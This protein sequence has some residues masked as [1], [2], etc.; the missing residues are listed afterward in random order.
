MRLRDILGL[1]RK[2]LWL[3]ILAC[4]IGGIAGL[5]VDHYQP[6]KYEADATLFVSSPNRSDYNTLLGD[7]QAAVA[8]AQYAKSNSVLLAALQKVGDSNLNLMQLTTMVTVENTL[9]SQFVT[10]KVLDTNPN[11]AALLASDIAREAMA[12]F[13]AT[14]TDSTMAQ[15]LQAEITKLA[16]QIKKQEEELAALQRQVAALRVVGTPTPEQTNTINRFNQLNTNLNNLRQLYTQDVNSYTNLT[17]IQVTLV[18]DAQVPQKPVGPGVSLAIAIGMLAGLIA[19]V[20]VILFIEQTD[21]VL[22]TPAKVEKE[23]GLSTLITVKRLPTL[24]KQVLLMNSHGGGNENTDKRQLVPVPKSGVSWEDEQDEFVDE[25]L[26]QKRV[27]TVAEQAPWLKN[28]R[29]LA[30]ATDPRL[31]AIAKQPPTVVVRKLPAVVNHHKMRVRA[32]NGF[33]LPEAFL[34]LGVFLRSE[35]SQVTSQGNN[36]G[37]LLITS[38]EDGDGKTLMSSQIALGL[39]RVGVEVILID[40]NLRK[41]EVHKLFKL[42]NDI[43][44]SSLLQ[45]NDSVYQESDDD[46][47]DEAS[48]IHAKLIDLILEA[49]QPTHEPNLSILPGGPS[50]DSSPEL[51]SLSTMKAILD[52]LSAQAFVI[53]DGPSVLT[54]SDSVILANKSDA[55]LLVVDARHTTATKLNQSL[56]MLSWVNTDILGV[57]LNQFGK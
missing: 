36:I 15:T 4:F 39:A 48:T 50:I 13:E 28:H 16:Q 49:V 2:W 10:I 53:I 9:N 57:V 37:S 41:P 27:T 26:T 21:E 19:I 8:L 11:R 1:A 14:V 44:L 51:L 12:Q 30:E 7:Q 29:D 33:R 42:S 46:S 25:A 43:G 45:V 17:S 56:E 20:G 32:T 34:T 18:Q 38:P 55:V 6:K 5:V 52:R 54:S 24:A 3:I 31:K 47:F 40:A 35:R 22:R 23:T